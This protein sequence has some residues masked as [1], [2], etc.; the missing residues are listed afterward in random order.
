[1]AITMRKRNARTALIIGISRKDRKIMVKK[2]VVEF[3]YYKDGCIMLDAVLT[4]END[5]LFIK[6][7][8]LED[9]VGFDFETLVNA[10]NTFKANPKKTPVW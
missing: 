3:G 2:M 1:M 7:P 9:E 4:A 8:C 5:T 10:I 6:L